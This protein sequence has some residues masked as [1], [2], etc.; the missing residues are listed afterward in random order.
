MVALLTSVRTQNVLKTSNLQ[1]KWGFVDPQMHTTV[2]T[3]KHESI[4]F[5][6]S[7]IFVTFTTKLMLPPQPL[8]AATSSWKVPLAFRKPTVEIF[9]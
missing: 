7:I 3:Q 5:K 2:R 6:N 1:H 8:V 9:H 4:A